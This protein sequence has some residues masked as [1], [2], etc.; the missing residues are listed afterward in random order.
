MRTNNNNFPKKL[1][2]GFVFNKTD[3]LVQNQNEQVILEEAIEETIKKFIFENSRSARLR[4][5]LINDSMLNKQNLFL[6]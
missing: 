2:N 5:R 6:R 1:S 3:Y 4:I